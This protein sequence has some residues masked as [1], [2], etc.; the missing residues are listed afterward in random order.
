MCII[1]N[2]TCLLQLDTFPFGSAMRYHFLCDVRLVVQW[3]MKM[4]RMT[5]AIY[6][7]KPTSLLATGRRQAHVRIGQSASALFTWLRTIAGNAKAWGRAT[8][9]AL[10]LRYKRWKSFE[11]NLR[12]GHASRTKSLWRAPLPYDNRWQRDSFSASYAP[13]QNSVTIVDNAKVL[14]LATPQHSETMDWLQ[15]A[16]RNIRSVLPP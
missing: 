4:R 1:R 9:R 14:V 3:R 8:A 12:H 7:P 11:N 13:R 15:P 6:F 5:E 16:T 10:C 2:Y